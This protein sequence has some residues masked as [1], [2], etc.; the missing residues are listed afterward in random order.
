MLNLDLETVHNPAL[1]LVV[2][3][4]KKLMITSL[5][6]LTPAVIHW[7]FSVYSSAKLG[8]LSVHTHPLNALSCKTRIVDDY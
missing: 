3:P 4:E 1:L 7:T 2:S 6:G 5:C 8:T